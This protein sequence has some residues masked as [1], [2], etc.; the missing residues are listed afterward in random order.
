MSTIDSPPGNIYLIRTFFILN[1]IYGSVG[2]STQSK[3]LELYNE[4]TFRLL[5]LVRSLRLI[6]FNSGLRERRGGQK[7][8]AEVA[9]DT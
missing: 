3:T 6:C 2:M 9:R 5:D 4:Q 1:N 7:R 8:A